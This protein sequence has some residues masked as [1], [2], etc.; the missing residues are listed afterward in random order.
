MAQLFLEFSTD[1]FETMHI[2]LIWSEDV[3]VG[4]GIIRLLY[5]FQIHNPL[6]TK[7]GRRGTLARHGLSSILEKA[8][9]SRRGGDGRVCVGGGV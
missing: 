6:L 7:P 1:Q 9:E 4:L 3:R 8:K 5:G 2:C